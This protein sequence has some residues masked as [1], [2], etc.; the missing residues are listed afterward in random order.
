MYCTAVGSRHP[1][2]IY[3][4]KINITC[5][6]R[7]K[8]YKNSGLTQ[9]GVHCTAVGS[10]PPGEIYPHKKPEEK[11]TEKNIKKEARRDQN[12]CNR[13]KNPTL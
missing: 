12:R 8:E 6:P 9:G 2:A 1:G 3:P 5:R 10:L 13:N 7:G 4:H 11:K